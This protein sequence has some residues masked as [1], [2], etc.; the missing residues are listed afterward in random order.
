MEMTNAGLAIMAGLFG[1]ILGITWLWRAMARPGIVERQDRTL[2][3]QHSRMDAMQ[4]EIDEL[5][6]AMLADREELN[7][8]RLE[9][10]EWRR[11][12]E[13]VFEQMAAA[14]MTP[15]WKPRVKEP[16][17]KGRLTLSQRIATQFN[18]D[19]INSLAYDIG[20]LSEEFGGDTVAKRAIEL[21]ELCS[22]RGITSALE[23]R[24]K[25]L[26]GI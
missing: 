26:R 21:V 2:T 5:R 23:A 4:S 12:M 1:A 24:V 10:N 6:A 8:L 15:V 3:Q 16:K 17:G 19:E 18:I 9:M 14:N 11:G 7:E 13:L 25:E 20:I 22:R